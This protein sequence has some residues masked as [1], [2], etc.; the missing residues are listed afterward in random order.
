MAITA[1]ATTKD[2][3]KPMPSAMKSSWEKAACDFSI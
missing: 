3:T 2:T 1:Q